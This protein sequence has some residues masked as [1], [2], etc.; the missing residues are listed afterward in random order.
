MNVIEKRITINAS[1]EFHTAVKMHALQHGY[2]TM[3]D[4]VMFALQAK[5]AEQKAALLKETERLGE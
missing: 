4:F 2:K 3:Q 1:S 5:M